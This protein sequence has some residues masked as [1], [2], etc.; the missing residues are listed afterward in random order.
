MVV[1]KTDSGGRCS[2]CGHSPLEPK[3]I[4]KT[5]EYGEGEETVTITAHQVPVR[6]CAKC[7]E[8]YSG[9]AAARV[10]HEAICQALGL[11]PPAGIKALR[12][13]FGWSQQYLADLTGLGIATV[14]R[15]ERGRHLQNRANNNVLLALRDCP[16]FREYLKG[17][18]ASKA[19]KSEDGSF[20]AT[21]PQGPTAA[22]TENDN[23][24]EF[25]IPEQAQQGAASR[26]PALVDR[27]KLR[28]S[29]HEEHKY[30]CF[31]L[32]QNWRDQ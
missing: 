14:S 31:A 26:W 10:E 23:P 27:I 21:P 20:P 4:D 32:H 17:L 3:L 29:N 16:A 8:Y 1:N 18:L 25:G 5:F 22:E 9:P 11:M 30:K 19:G 28:S 24:Q 2:M 13:R 7:G 6:A 12:D 15:L